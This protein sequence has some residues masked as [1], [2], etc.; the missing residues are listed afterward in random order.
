[1]FEVG[2]VHDLCTVSCNPN[3][4]NVAYAVYQKVFFHVHILPNLHGHK[5]KVITSYNDEN[6]E[7]IFVKWFQ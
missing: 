2:V 1:M 7:N 4:N 6:N 5:L 3:G